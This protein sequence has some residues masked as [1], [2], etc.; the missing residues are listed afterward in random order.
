MKERPTAGIATDGA[1]SMKERLTR[2][3]AVDLSSG[4][5]LFSET[6]GNW[7][8]NI[9]EFLGIVAAVRYILE[10]PGSPRVIYSDSITAITWYHQRQ[11]ASSRRCLALLK[12]EIFLK[13]MDAKIADIEV[14]YWNNRLWGEIPADYGNK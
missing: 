3:R 9:G 8:N 12:A 5:E 6:V 14:L 13:A 2:F 7:T 4:A 10:H 1:H 11:T